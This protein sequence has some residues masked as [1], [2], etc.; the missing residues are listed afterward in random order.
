VSTDSRITSAKSALAVFC[1]TNKGT[2]VLV[3]DANKPEPSSTVVP[4]TAHDLAFARQ[5]DHALEWEEI[6]AGLP[7]L[8]GLIAPLW[9]TAQK[10]TM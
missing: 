5:S 1:V 3:L 7:R 6:A 4:V 2:A 9:E 10:N 8:S